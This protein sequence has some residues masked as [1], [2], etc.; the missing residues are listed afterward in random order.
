M[1]IYKGTETTEIKIKNK[2]EEKLEI[3][4]ISKV[5]PDIRQIS[6]IIDNNEVLI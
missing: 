2:F 6:L 3:E 4:K 5:S 1:S